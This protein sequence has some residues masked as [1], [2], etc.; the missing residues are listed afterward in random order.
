VQYF[1]GI[2]G[3]L[4]ID[5]TKAARVVSWSLSANAGLLDTTTLGDTDRTTIYGTRSTTGSCQ[6]YYYQPEAGTKGDASTLLNALIKARTNNEDPGVAP[7]SEKILLRLKID[8][9]TTEGKYVELD[10]NLTTASMTM[11]VGTVLAADISFEATGA[12]RLVNI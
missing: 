9:S 7:Q 12:P 3:Q 10:A 8:D 1:S 5:G 4:Y 6:L 11:A 2:S